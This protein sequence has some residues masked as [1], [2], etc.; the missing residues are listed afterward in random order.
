VCGSISRLGLEQIAALRNAAPECATL[1][2]DD[3]GARRHREAKRLGR[4]GDVASE[5]RETEQ[6]ALAEAVDDLERGEDAALKPTR[7]DWNAPSFAFGLA[8][9]QSR[10]SFAGNGE[11]SKS[12]SRPP[13]ASS[14]AGVAPS[15]WPSFL[16]LTW[17]RSAS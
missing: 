14:A 8:S 6:R 11:R 15:A 16:L 4:D 17:F 7:T 10:P 2:L 5:G 1:L 3:V 9:A 12:R 13:P